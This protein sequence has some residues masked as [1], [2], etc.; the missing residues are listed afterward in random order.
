MNSRGSLLQKISFFDVQVQ[1]EQKKKCPTGGMVLATS[2]LV[3][4][5][6]S[7]TRKSLE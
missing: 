3:G 4:R 5:S 6:T 7:S 1:Q 2:T